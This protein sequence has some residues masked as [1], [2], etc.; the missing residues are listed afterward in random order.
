MKINYS[1]CFFPLLAV[2]L[3]FAGCTKDQIKSPQNVLDT[4]VKGT[5][6]FFASISDIN[7]TQTKG[8]EVSVEQIETEIR[9]LFAPAKEY[10]RV[11]QYDYS[12]DFDENDPNIILAAFSLMESDLYFSEIEENGSIKLTDAL[13]CVFLGE[14]V[15][16]LSKLGVQLLVKRCAKKVLERSIPY[17]GAVVGVATAAECLREHWGD[18]TC[19]DADLPHP[20]RDRFVI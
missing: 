19:T 7:F 15:S 9:P 10:L 6:D 1:L 12:E 3:M 16:D 2:L 20:D 8:G 4:E 18:G 5:Q 13:S 14:G 11:N 17:I